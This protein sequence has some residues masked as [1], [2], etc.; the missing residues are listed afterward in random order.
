[1]SGMSSMTSMGDNRQ[2]QSRLRKKYMSAIDE[3][4]IR[5]EEVKL[6]EKNYGFQGREGIEY[7]E[8]QER[9]RINTE[10]ARLENKL[11]TI[12]KEIETLNVDLS[13]LEELILEADTNIDGVNDD[14]YRALQAALPIKEG[15]LRMK[16]NAKENN[17]T[18]TKKE[19]ETYNDRIEKEKD[20]FNNNNLKLKEMLTQFKNNKIYLQKKVSENKKKIADLIKDYN[21]LNKKLHSYYGGFKSKVVKRKII[22][23]KAKAKPTA[24]K[25]TKP[26]RPVVRR[27]KPTIVRR[28]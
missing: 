26:T 6:E 15:Y 24:R 22:P 18:L 13:V 9:E 11:L 4:E 7:R 27:R 14:I 2:P 19:I 20:E 28:K 23:V 12:E 21:E 10:K 17:R 25:P 3:A 16:R 1:M 8:I 5:N